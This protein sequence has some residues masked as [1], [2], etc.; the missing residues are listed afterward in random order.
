MH[1]MHSKEFDKTH[2]ILGY[3]GE[4]PFSVKIGFLSFKTK[5]Y[6]PNPTRC[7]QC[8]K[9]GHVAQNC[10]GSLSCPKCGGPH[11]FTDCSV[12]DLKCS[13]CGGSHSASDKS[14]PT[15]LKNK[16]IVIIKHQNRIPYSEALKIDKNHVTN[17]TVHAGTLKLPLGNV[18]CATHVQASAPALQ[19]SNH[20]PDMPP[21]N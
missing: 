14:C 15:F 3:L 16:D 11:N 13:N 4:A 19:D 12:E 17:T 6:I 10:R 20:F 7:Y 21:S 1:K 5:V 2:Y 9:Y 8:N 18:S